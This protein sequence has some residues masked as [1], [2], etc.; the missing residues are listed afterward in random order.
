MSL[1][2]SILFWLLYCFFAVVIAV[3]GPAAQFCML[4]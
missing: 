4:S 3:S 2:G 1:P